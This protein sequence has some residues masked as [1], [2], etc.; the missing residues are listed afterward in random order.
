MW[1]HGPPPSSQHPLCLERLGLGP[2]VG[3]HRRRA[4]AAAAPALAVVCRLPH[5]TCPHEGRLRSSDWKT[6]SPSETVPTGGAKLLNPYSC[7]PVVHVRLRLPSFTNK[8]QYCLIKHQTNI[9]RWHPEGQRSGDAHVDLRCFL[10]HKPRVLPSPR[11]RRATMIWSQHS[12]L[13]WL[14]IRRFIL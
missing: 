1:V 7:R 5:V 14:V 4:A 2:H 13:S 11:F 9:R 3:L 8:T 10:P 6:L 12:L